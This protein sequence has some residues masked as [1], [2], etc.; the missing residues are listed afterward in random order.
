MKRIFALLMIIMSISTTV[1]AQ[2]KLPLMDK[3]PMDM[4][5]YPTGYPLLKIQDKITEPLAMRVIY[6][7]PQLNGR[8]AFGELRE[9]G[10]IW[11]LGANEASELEFYKDVKLAG[12][13]IKKGRYTIYCIPY[14]DKWT[15]IINKETDTWGDFKYDQ[16]KDAIRFDVPVSKVTESTEALTMLFDKILGGAN[17][18]IYWDDVKVA[19]PILF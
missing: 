16:T 2:V 15:M 7:R 6:S 10:K 19:V 11:R 17:L 12:K 14:S 3:S 18:L 5:Y 8:R 4:S 13:K 9:M 1:N